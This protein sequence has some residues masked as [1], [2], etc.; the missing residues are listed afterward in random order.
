M[1]KYLKPAIA[2]CLVAALAIGGTLAYLTDSTATVTNTFTA[3]EN[4]DIDLYET[5]D[6]SEV[7]TKDYTIIPGDEEAK[8]PT[9]E[10]EAGSEDVYVYVDVIENN[11]TILTDTSF[12]DYITYSVSS[13]WREVTVT[14]NTTGTK[15][16]VYTNDTDAP[17]AVS[18]EAKLY[19]LADV[20]NTIDDYT[21]ANG[22]VVYPTSVTNE[23]LAA[24]DG[25]TADGTADSNETSPT[26]EFVAY[27][28]QADNLLPASANASF[29]EYFKTT[30]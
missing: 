7:L 21:N 22:S 9:V 24:I 11:G 27:A 28:V 15:T 1:K 29:I 18:A 14:N 4:I 19:I 16:Y 25:V 17:V 26:L 13:N 8:D 20:E 2:L 12:S 6:G 23:M 10:V 3:G 5:N 30:T